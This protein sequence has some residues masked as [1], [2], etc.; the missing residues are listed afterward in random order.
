MDGGLKQEIA[1]KGYAIVEGV[2]DSDAIQEIAA[3]YEQLLDRLA[4]EWH[5]QGRISSAFDGLPFAERLTTVISDSNE[6][7]FQHFDITLPNDTV[8]PETPFHVSRATYDFLRNE[9]LLDKVEEVIG[10]EILSNPIQHVRIKPPQHRVESLSSNLLKA[11]GWH[12]DRGVARE[13]ADD[14]GML[15][16][17]IAVTDAT[18][19]NGCLKVA[20]YSHLNGLAVHCML[21]HLRIPDQLLSGEPLPLPIKAGDAIF[22]HSDTQHGSLPNVSDTIRWSFDLR[23]QPIG[24]PTGRDE[25]PS[26]VVRSRENPAQVGD[27]ESWREAWYS[28]RDYLAGVDDR[29][30]TNRWDGTAIECA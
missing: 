22:M 20:P 3:D 16:V 21:D 13:V 11:T 10:G 6:D 26:L 7:L 8:T 1:A 30:S 2:L 23:Y 9:A 24:L 29:E 18:L 17:W 14:S 27:Y 19:E 25:F 5:A 28:A 12:Q 4:L 15:T